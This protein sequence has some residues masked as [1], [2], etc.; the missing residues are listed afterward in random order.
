MRAPPPPGLE[1]AHL[2]PDANSPADTQK[3]LPGLAPE[4]SECFR[5][6]HS[7]YGLAVSDI[8][9]ESFSDRL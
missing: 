1:I 6:F 9:R 5:E 3:V 4:K 2:F 8:Q 7:A